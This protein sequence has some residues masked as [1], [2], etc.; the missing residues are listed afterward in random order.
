VPDG[1]ECIES[2]PTGYPADLNHGSLRTPS[3]YICYRRGYHKPPLVDVG[4]L[5]E[6]KGER[7]M[8]DSQVIKHTPHGRNANVNNATPGIFLTYR[9][10]ADNAP[11]NQLAVTD[12]CVILANKGE[13]APHTYCQVMKDLNKG[14]VGSS[15][16]LCYKKSMASATRIAYEPVL[17]DRFPTT[18]VSHFVL[19]EKLPTFCLP[20]GAVIECWPAKCQVRC[21]VTCTTHACVCRHPPRRSVRLC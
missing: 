9:R 11:P 16:F 19:P 13:T 15:V 18:D 1:F 20:M 14:M 21:H 5:Y 2:T 10:A 6:G 4:V 8:V 17:I 3:C 12:I 7:V